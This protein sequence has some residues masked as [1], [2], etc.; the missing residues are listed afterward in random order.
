[1]MTSTYIIDI[2]RLTISQILFSFL[3][4]VGVQ[5]TNSP[6]LRRG[7][8]NDGVD[9]VNSRFLSEDMNNEDE[10][11]PLVKNLVILSLI[12]LLIGVLVK[13]ICTEYNLKM[14]L[15]TLGLL[16]ASA[17][18]DES[19]QER[20]MT[21]AERVE[22]KRLKLVDA[23]L[24]ANSVVI[25]EKNFTCVECEEQSCQ[26]SKSSIA[27]DLELYIRVDNRT[28]PSTC[29]VCLTQYEPG[30]TLVHSDNHIGTSHHTDKESSDE[31]FGK[32]RCRHMFHLE[33]IKDWLIRQRNGT[34]CPCCRM[35]FLSTPSRADIKEEIL[36]SESRAI[37][38]NAF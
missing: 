19:I 26:R 12:I 3:F 16:P 7:V 28:I 35:E 33:C 2:R 37:Y 36:R 18:N 14:Y 8:E 11:E 38:A 22:A 15:A 31:E 10:E 13:S 6:N 34:D 21:V 20:I 1:M 4:V 23:S 29:A 32:H 25:N 27:D 17:I 24:Q 5:G 9:V 30:D